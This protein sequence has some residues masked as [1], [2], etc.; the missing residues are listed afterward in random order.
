MAK[1]LT[2]FLGFELTDE[3]INQLPVLL[4]KASQDDQQKSDR[5]HFE[6]VI[7]DWLNYYKPEQSR[8]IDHIMISRFETLGL[9]ICCDPT[10]ATK[11]LNNFGRIVIDT[12]VNSN[13]HNSPK[14]NSSE[15][16]KLAKDEFIL[17]RHKSLSNIE[18]V[19]ENAR[20]GSD[21]V[22]CCSSLYR[23]CCPCIGRQIDFTRV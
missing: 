8:Q 21:S 18:I 6:G 2:N 5:R 23:F 15:K 9:S 11:R 4:Q 16:T 14:K 10:E 19:N 3:D 17:L 1:L 22:N 7:G 20:N 12:K 13:Q